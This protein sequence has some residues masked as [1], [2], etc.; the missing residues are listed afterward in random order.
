MSSEHGASD[1]RWWLLLLA[2][3]LAAAFAFQGSRG[4]YESTEGRYAES[5][6][7]MLVSGD[8]L[9]PT[10]D[11]RPHWTKP[12]LS[13]WAVAGGMAVFGVNEWGARFANGLAF[14]LTA[15]CVAAIADRLWGRSAALAAGL[16]YATSFYPAYGANALSTDALLTLFEV[17]AVAAYLLADPGRRG[18]I[19]AMWCFFGLAF[20]TKGPPGLLPLL[21]ILAWHAR[22][23]ERPRLFDFWGVLL[24]FV[25]GFTWY[26][27]V[28]VRNPGLLSY[29]VGEE[30]VNRVASDQFRRNP[31]WWKPFVIYLPV[32]LLGPGIWL[33]PAARDLFS[34][35]RVF[36]FRFFHD[37]WRRNSPGLFLWLW[38]LLPLVVFFVVK[39]RLNLYVLPLYAPIALG[40]AWLLSRIA[41]RPPRTLCA[42]A[43]IAATCIVSVRG[44][45]ALWPDKNDMSRIEKLLTE[46]SALPERIFVYKQPLFHGLQFYVEGRMQRVSD[47]GKESWA[48][49][50]LATVLVPD[51]A[52]T[53]ALV[54]RNRYA[55]KIRPI[56]EEAGIPFRETG[57]RF[58]TVFFY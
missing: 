4:L 36:S 25:V 37:L 48:C 40:I 13:Y 19:F 12:P 17:A 39:S 14:V 52:E 9:V 44:A 47:T 53:T 55:D 15:F 27:V 51:P 49:C 7:E 46:E 58:Y 1:P 20:L 50:P 24:F 28:I 34:H 43:L 54:L 21:P 56:L 23:E 8:Y 22:R 41:R 45:A 18:W 29:F 57:D 33:V 26:A 10:L 31:Q 2:L 6:R 3:A 32:L 5:A 38:L 16:I 30:I 42:F 11:G 35:R